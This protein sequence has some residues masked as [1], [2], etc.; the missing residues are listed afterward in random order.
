[1]GKLFG[2][3]IERA[4]DDR[5][6]RESLQDLDIGVVLHL[7]GRLGI[8]LEIQKLGSVQADA[9]GAAFDAVRDFIGEF[10]IAV[11]VNRNPSWSIVF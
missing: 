3:Q 6:G 5:T 10:N 4:D 7:F 8:A 1:M 11:D 9:L 2:P